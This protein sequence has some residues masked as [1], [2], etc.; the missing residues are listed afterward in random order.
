MDEVKRRFGQLV[1]EE[2]VAADF[3]SIARELVEE[4]RVEIHRKHRARAPDPL[5]EHPGDRPSTR[6]DIQA[7]PAL[8][9]ANRVQLTD[10]QRI[11]VL[12]QQLQPSPLHIWRASL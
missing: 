2:V 4:A 3:D 5:G 9:N 10:G 6:A 7:A 1:G 8:A 12:L 11:V